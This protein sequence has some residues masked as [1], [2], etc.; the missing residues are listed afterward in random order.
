[1]MDMTNSY[2]QEIRDMKDL[3]NSTNKN[4]VDQIKKSMTDK[5]TK[6]R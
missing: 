5:M 4:T 2:Q 6:L 1:M 3:I